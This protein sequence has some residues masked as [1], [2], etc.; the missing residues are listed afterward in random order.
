MSLQRLISDNRMRPGLYN[1]LWFLVASIVDDKKAHPGRI[2]NWSSTLSFCFDRLLSGV[3][4]LHIYAVVQMYRSNREL[5][6]GYF[7][8]TMH[9]FITA[10]KFRPV[11]DKTIK[12]SEFGVPAS[13]GVAA[14]ILNR[15]CEAKAEHILLCL[16]HFRVMESHLGAR[17]MEAH[18]RTAILRDLA[19]L[20]IQSVLGLY[21]VS[22][23]LTLDSNHGTNGEQRY[24]MSPFVY[25][26]QVSV[27]VALLD[28][29]INSSQTTQPIS[30]R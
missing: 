20:N 18:A 23:Q 22:S 8:Q 15:L 11:D 19:A 7:E 14:S 16:F 26:D 21:Y 5:L 25:G 2:R 10:L 24:W 12:S 13:Q 29:G 9:E 28:S 6:D 4:K 17:W 30:D 3:D 27:A 1:L